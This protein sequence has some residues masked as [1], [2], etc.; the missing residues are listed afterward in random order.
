MKSAGTA[1]PRAALVGNPSDG[2]FGKTIAIAFDNFSA[3]VNVE[4]AP[5]FSIAKS[6][7]PL[8]GAALEVFSSNCLRRSAE[9]IHLSMTFETD[10]PF[11]LGLGG[12][13]AIVIACMRALA[14][15]FEID[16]P[17]EVMAEF[18]LVAERD[19]LGIPAGLQ[20]RVVQCLGGVLYMDFDRTVVDARGFG[21]YVPIDPAL[22]P[23]LFVAYMPE[24]AEGSEVTHSELRSRYDAGDRK[25]LTAIEEWKDLTVRVLDLLV[26]GK[27]SEIGPYLD[28]NF[29]IRRELGLA[30]AGTIAMA[31]A[32]CALGASANSAGSGGAI[33]GTYAGPEMFTCLVETLSELGASV[34]EPSVSL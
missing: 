13:S 9:D 10:I 22:L 7:A 2:Y 20:D 26:S 6:G 32:A 28:R 11:K 18:A 19:L 31:E 24:A 12:S 30:S 33:V 8:L 23:A 1:H 5:A 15:Y 34:I 25:V 17:P 21:E 14:D 3:R 4:E 27:G 29:A 16:V